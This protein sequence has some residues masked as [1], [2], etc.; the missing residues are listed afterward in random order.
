MDDSQ[1][2]A[3]AGDPRR[4]TRVCTPLRGSKWDGKDRTFDLIAGTNFSDGAGMSPPR[5]LYVAFTAKM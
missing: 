2:T 3:F 5:Q 4:A 1:K